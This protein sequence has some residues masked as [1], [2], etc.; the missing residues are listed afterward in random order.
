MENENKYQTDPNVQQA[1]TAA[2]AEEKQRKKKKKLIIFGVVAAVIVF[3]IVVG[4]LGGSDENK[5]AQGNS[6]ENSTQAVNAVQE[7]KKDDIIGDFGCKVKSAKPC[8]DSNG[9][10][11][12]IVT[13]EFTNNSNEA[14]SFA[15]ALTD[16]VYQNDVELEIATLDE[17]NDIAD[18]SD[19]LAEVEPGATKEIKKAYVLNDDSTSLKVEIV[20]AFSLNDEKITKTVNITK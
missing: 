16:F 7:N 9:K 2:F 11:A 1:V 12:V 14:M 17:K 3:F 13:Y 15:S 4:S 18:D 6:P 19:A 5:P 10:N 20:E 8:K